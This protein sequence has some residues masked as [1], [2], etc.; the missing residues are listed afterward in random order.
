[1]N[2]KL[3][4]ILGG[5]LVIILGGLSFLF[6]FTYSV[7]GKVTDVTNK[8]P[9]KSV[10][11]SVAGHSQTTDEQGNYKISGIK[12]YQKKNLAVT[13]PS[14]FVKPTDISVSYN[15]RNAQKDFTL[16]P[17]LTE[18]VNRVLVG[19]SNGQYDYLYDLMNPDDQ[20]YWV[21]KDNYK[22]LLS[23]RDKVLSALNYSTKSWTIGQNVRQLDT[24]KSPITGKEYKNVWEVPETYTKV[25]NGQDQPATNLDYFQ[26]VNGFYHYFTSLNKD[27]VQKA[28]NAF[29]G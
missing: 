3:R 7:S 19:Y 11:V 21:S 23:Q 14:Q 12:I 26:E 6:L 27:D 16:E 5:I 18:T 17:T 4:F 24:W 25:I 10:K 28:I 13:P 8:Q 15:S 2:K 1:M 29:N 22:N 20:A 9:V